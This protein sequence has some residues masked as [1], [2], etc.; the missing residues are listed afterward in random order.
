MSYLVF[1][2]SITGQWNPTPKMVVE[3]FDAGEFTGFPDVLAKEWEVAN[4]DTTLTH[5]TLV[6]GESV[7]YTPPESPALDTVSQMLANIHEFHLATMRNTNVTETA[8]KELD[9]RIVMLREFVIRAPQVVPI[10]WA[11]MKSVGYTW[12][13]PQVIDAVEE[14]ALKTGIPLVV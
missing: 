13:T 4:G 2:R 7:A 1:F 11:Q 8:R 9:S 14:E 3:Q 10:Y 5:Y 6:G 12:L